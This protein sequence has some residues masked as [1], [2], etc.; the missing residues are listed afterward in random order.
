[1]SM[2]ARHLLWHLGVAAGAVVVLSLFGVP[3]S[4]AL[5]IGIMAGC[6]AMVFHGG[7]GA[8]RHDAPA[9]QPRPHREVEH[10]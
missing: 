1:M 8:H 9:Q 10:R 6:V 3:F 4:S 5:P 2:L 7:H